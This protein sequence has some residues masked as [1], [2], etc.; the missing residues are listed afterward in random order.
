MEGFASQGDEESCELNVNGYSIIID[1]NGIFIPCTADHLPEKDKEGVR[2]V[3]GG[4]SSSGSMGALPFV[5][6]IIFGGAVWIYSSKAQKSSKK[7][8]INAYLQWVN[9]PNNVRTIPLKMEFDIGRS[10]SADLR[11]ADAKVSRIH[12]RIRYAQGAWYIQDQGSAGGTF[13]NGQRI[14][15]KRLDNGDRIRIGSSEFEFRE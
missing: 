2:E 13:V 10:R 5:L 3:S 1:E 7:L 12:A 15:A 14:Q 9:A 8:H 4:T 11:L 6:L